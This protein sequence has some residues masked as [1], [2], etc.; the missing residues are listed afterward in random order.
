MER[1]L[2]YLYL[3]FNRDGSVSAPRDHFLNAELLNY[4]TITIRS[5]INLLKDDF[6]AEL[7][8]INW[9]RERR[10]REKSCLGSGV[11]DFRFYE[12]LRVH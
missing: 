7:G 2:V 3:V 10:K 12:N 1:L 5:I 8:I 4:L 6:T 11:I 9:L